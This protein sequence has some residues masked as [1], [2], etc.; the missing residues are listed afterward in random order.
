MQAKSTRFSQ[1]YEQEAAQYHARRYETRYGSLFRRL[2]HHVLSERLQGL[3]ASNHVLEVACGTG[4]TTELLSRQGFQLT[5][6]DLTPQMMSQARERLLDTGSFVRADAFRLPFPND[7][8]DAV[9]STRF[10]HLFP[11]TEQR[12]LLHEMHRV[13]KPEGRLIV[14][15]DNFTS[16][17]IMAAPYFLYNLFRYRR[18]APYAVYNRIRSTERVLRDVGFE[19]VRTDGIGGTHLVLS[20]WISSALAFQFGLWHRHRLLRMMAEQFMVCG[21]KKA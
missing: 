15:F 3:N 2:H 14:D 16:R 5:A 17:W 4:H 8:F 10:L 18:S 1:F 7:T 12:S 9:V 20:A 6:T 19:N 21:N 13:L 11:C